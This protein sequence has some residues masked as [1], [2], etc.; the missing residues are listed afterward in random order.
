M[1]YNLMFL[2]GLHYS[3]CRDSRIHYAT[4]TSTCVVLSEKLLFHELVIW[5]LYFYAER[6][7]YALSS[8][9]QQLGMGK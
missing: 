6:R 4:L 1:F 7:K 3:H 2:L 5:S 8:R 9:T